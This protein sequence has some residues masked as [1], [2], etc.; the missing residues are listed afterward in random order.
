MKRRLR[1]RWYLVVLV[2]T[3]T[4]LFIG[5]SSQQAFGQALLNISVIDVEAGFPEIRTNI[6]LL[7]ENNRVP[8]TVDPSMFDVYENGQRIEEFEIVES[9]DV[10]KL[11]ALHVESGLFSTA[12]RDYGV[13]EIRSSFGSLVSGG[14]FATGTDTLI[15]TERI[16]VD[17]KDQTVVVIEPTSTGNELPV[18]LGKISF[19]VINSDQGRTEGF[20]GL[21]DV[22][23]LVDD[24]AAAGNIGQS[25]LIYFVHNINWPVQT[26][27]IQL[28][29]EIGALARDRGV[30]IYVVHANPKGEFPDPFELMAEES[31]GLYLNPS[32][33]DNLID[34]FEE[35][36]L[37]LNSQS[38]T[39]TIRFDSQL[40]EP[41][42]R[43]IAVLPAGVPLDQAQAIGSVEV[44]PDPATVVIESRPRVERVP[45][46]T[47]TVLEPNFTP[48]LARVDGWPY[49]LKPGDLLSAELIVDGF[50][51]ETIDNPDPTT[52]QFTL[53]VS[54][55]DNP[56]STEVQVR[57]TDNFGISATS[58]RTQFIIDVSPLIETAVDEEPL[59]VD[60]EPE[61]APVSAPVSA[62]NLNI[63]TLLP[64]ILTAIMFLALVAGGIYFY[65]KIAELGS[66]V[67]RDAYSRGGVREWTKTILG[68]S[69]GGKATVF[70]T[71][72]VLKGPSDLIS[73]VVEIY[74]NN[75][76]IGRD[77]AQCD[78]LLYEQD[79][80]CS[81][82]GLHC[83]I[84]NDLGQFFITDS[85]NNGTKLNSNIL[86]RDVPV[87]LNHGD[88]ILL[89]D[90]FRRGA[91]LRFEI[92]DAA[93]SA[94]EDSGSQMK[95]PVMPTFNQEVKAQPEVKPQVLA[96]P[97]QDRDKTV[98]EFA[99]DETENIDLPPNVLPSEMIPDIDDDD[100]QNKLA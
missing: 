37:D 12:G 41:G 68:G 31:G 32:K 88:E 92:V 53:N 99:D 48:V 86:M 6:R 21:R 79:T 80:A 83:T 27:Q 93:W 50:V 35:I 78:I 63:A 13:S 61:P 75:T 49:P 10:P 47:G 84:Q 16:F 34:R 85:S 39:Y 67:A 33:D 7:D 98:L 17:N 77:P 43:E 87:E 36:Y 23:D 90:L 24:T 46:A 70:A 30:Q 66:G 96:E 82:S 71:L 15:L 65:R 100:W 51:E 26:Q 1:T 57:A 11:V 89:G 19:D 3:L 91:L 94:E 22:L 25:A 52:L 28:A 54:Q 4:T 38:Q 81:I 60:P 64:W 73:E 45:N 74:S 5:G 44:N 95:A 8:T 14:Y 42:I 69:T 9:Q 58:D 2:L 56:G 62:G 97:V 55:F 59:V 72:K 76:T 18:G 29:R 40:V 20:K